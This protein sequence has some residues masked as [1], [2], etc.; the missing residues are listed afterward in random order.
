MA[1]IQGEVIAPCGCRSDGHPRGP[2]KIMALCARGAELVDRLNSLSTTFGVDKVILKAA[3]KALSDHLSVGAVPFVPNAQP[4]T[5]TQRSDVAKCR[6]CR[7]P[8]VFLKRGD[9]RPHP[10]D[11]ATCNIGDERF[12]TSKGHVSHFRT[13]PNADDWKGK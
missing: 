9:G 13:C 12:E 4:K 10:V 8:I 6:S 11:A 1:R 5:G 2:L 3:Q 7:A